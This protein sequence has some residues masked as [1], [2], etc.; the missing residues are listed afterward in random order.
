MICNKSADGIPLGQIVVHECLYNVQVMWARGYVTWLLIGRYRVQVHATALLSGDTNQFLPRE[1]K[2][3]HGR[4][5]PLNILYGIRL[6]Q[7]YLGFQGNIFTTAFWKRRQIIQLYIDASKTKIMF[8]WGSCIALMCLNLTLLVL[9]Y[10]YPGFN[11][12]VI[13]ALMHFK[14]FIL[15]GLFSLML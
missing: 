7:L 9:H 11:M 8:Y 2:W 14:E 5:H 3:R 15:A 6:P 10:L 1:G 12:A 13:M 4:V